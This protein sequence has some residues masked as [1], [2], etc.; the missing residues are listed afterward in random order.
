SRLKEQAYRFI[1]KPIYCTQFHPELNRA[2][3]L[4]R[5]VAYP[6]YVVRIAQITYDEFVQNVRETPEANGLL[7]RFASV[8]FGD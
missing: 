3:M 7:R 4:E 2:A 5:V 1:G 8:V 6:E